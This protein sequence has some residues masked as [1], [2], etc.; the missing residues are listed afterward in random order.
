MNGRNRLLVTNEPV[1]VQDCRKISDHF[2]GICG[3]YL[4]LMKK[5]RKITTRN[6][7]NLET[8]GL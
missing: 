8:L 2:R 4:E 7:W 3:I 5:T 1:E 6:H